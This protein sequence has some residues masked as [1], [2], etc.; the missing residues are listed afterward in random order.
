MGFALLLLFPR[1]SAT[2]LEVYACRTIEGTSYLEA[3][4]S[5]H[6]HT[7]TFVVFEELLE[8]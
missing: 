5:I 2:V 3:D 7:S 8:L 4:Y 6:C 1:I